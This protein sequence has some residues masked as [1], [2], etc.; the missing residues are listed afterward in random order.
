MKT[1]FD[2]IRFIYEREDDNHGFKQ[3]VRSLKEKGIAA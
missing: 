2:G 1:E 3:W